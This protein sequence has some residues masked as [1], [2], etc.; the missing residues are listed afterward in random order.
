LKHYRKYYPDE[1]E[2]SKE[3]MGPKT[4]DEYK[5]IRGQSR[6][7]SK[8]WLKSIFSREKKDASGEI[9]TVKEVG[10]FKGLITVQNKLVVDS[11]E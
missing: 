4:F 11:H 9:S 6:G 2:N 7:I 8:S 3:M 10:K 5:L 1:L